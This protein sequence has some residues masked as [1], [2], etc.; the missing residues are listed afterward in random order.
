MQ[1]KLASWSSEDKSRKFDRLLR[2]ITN[3]SWLLQAASADF[4]RLLEKTGC[5]QSMSRKGNCLDNAVAESF[6]HTL[7]TQLTHHVRFRDK[8]EAELALFNYIEAYYN[9]RRHHSA[10]DYKTPA[11]LEQYV[12]SLQ[13]VT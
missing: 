7:K 1:G 10:I 3:R 8:N 6:F 12:E 9:R 2:V 11:E 13:G 5:V 4:R